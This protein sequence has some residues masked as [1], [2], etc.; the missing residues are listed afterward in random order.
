[1]AVTVPFSVTA[2]VTTA[3]SFTVRVPMVVLL[4]LVSG[5]LLSAVAVSM[6]ALANTVRVSVASKDDHPSEINCK[7][8]T[9]EYDE[10]IGISN[11]VLIAVFPDTQE[12]LNSLDRDGEAHGA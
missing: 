9:A 11:K 1:V 4:A 6:S 7:P 3:A 2:T 10:F 8:S 12:L 5:G